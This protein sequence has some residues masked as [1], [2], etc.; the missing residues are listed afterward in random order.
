MNIYVDGSGTNGIKC[1]Y[2]VMTGS[3]KIL[4]HEVFTGNEGRATNNE[5]EYKAVI[6]ALKIAQDGMQEAKELLKTKNVRL[7]WIKR[8]D[9]VAG[10]YLERY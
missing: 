2:C 3:G 5:M 6:E 10:W 8:K 9:N 1:S 7:E 4:K